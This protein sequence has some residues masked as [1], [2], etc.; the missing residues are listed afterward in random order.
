MSVTAEQM[1]KA[2]ELKE[3]LLDAYDPEAVILFGSLGRG[4]GDEFSDVDFLVVMESDRDTKTLSEEMTR[5]LDP[6]VRDKHVIA[7]TPKEFCRQRDI[8][9]TLAFSAVNEGRVLFEKAGWQGGHVSV[10]CYETRKQEVI[11][12]SYLK[13]AQDFLAQAQGSLEAGNLFR[14]RDS[15]RFAAARALKGLFVRHDIQPPRETD[16][17]GLLEKARA[18]DPGLE[19]H[20]PFLRELNSY[21]PGGN[22]T[23]EI[24]KCRSMIEGTAAFV[25]EMIDRCA[26]VQ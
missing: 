9:G 17:V 15:V 10:D 16:L 23:L 4:D 24:R 20:A 8:P 12:Q 25:K 2:L 1:A 5:Y 18:L 13:E 21:C 22:E 3:A 6:L 26:M 11:R 14:C 19:V 7:R